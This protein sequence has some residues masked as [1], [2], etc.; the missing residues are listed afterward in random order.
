MNFKQKIYCA[1]FIF[2]L[3]N[4]ADAIITLYAL[5]LH[6]PFIQE[7]N[8]IHALTIF[9][10]DMKVLILPTILELFTVIWIELYRKHTILLFAV[11]LILDIMFTIVVINNVVVLCR[12][13]NS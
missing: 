13:I 3:L 10:I 5:N 9:N 4:G 12:A 2:I 11:F 8:T 6:S 1:S 7:S